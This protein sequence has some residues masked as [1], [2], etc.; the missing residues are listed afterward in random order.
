MKIDANVRVKMNKA[1]RAALMRSPQV[2]GD[3]VRRA[4]AIAAEAGSGHFVDSQLWPLR[5]RAAVVTRT[6]EAK[7][8]EA[9]DRNLTQAIDAGKR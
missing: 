8:A 1:G 4:E 7:H 6:F 2:R 5:A 9:T 3:L